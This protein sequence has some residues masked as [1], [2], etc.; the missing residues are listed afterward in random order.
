MEAE[1]KVEPEAAPVAC[2]FTG[3]LN[4][5][6][7]IVIETETDECRRLVVEAGKELGV[8]VECGPCK[9]AARRM[10]A[11]MQATKVAAEA[12]PEPEPLEVELR[13]PEPE[14]APDTRLNPTES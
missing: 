1:T 6:G 5:A 2:K 10:V 12:K 8:K 14:P 4:E 11:S 13:E 7:E 3:Y 9:E